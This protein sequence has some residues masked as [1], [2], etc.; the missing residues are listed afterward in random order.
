MWKRAADSNAG[1]CLQS[2]P[3]VISFQMTHGLIES[4]YESFFILYKNTIVT[5]PD[6]TAKNDLSQIE[7]LNLSEIAKKMLENEYEGVNALKCI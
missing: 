4:G 3:R 2:F 7:Q 1:V 5:R 6:Q